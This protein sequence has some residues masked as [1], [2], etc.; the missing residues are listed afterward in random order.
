MAESLCPK[1]RKSID[2]EATVCPYC[3]SAFSPEDMATRRADHKS[4]MVAGGVGC[5]VLVI[6]AGALA[7]CTLREEPKT[8]DQ[9]KAAALQYRGAINRNLSI[10]HTMILVA[11]DKLEQAEAGKTDVVSAYSAIQEGRDACNVAAT[12]ITLLPKITGMPDAAAAVYRRMDMDCAV[13]ARGHVDALDTMLQ[14]LDGKLSTGGLA[15]GLKQ[16]ERTAFLAQ[17]C[18]GDLDA[19][20]LAAGAKSGDLD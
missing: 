12:E 3:Q 17:K 6:A 7:M 16:S 13:A 19:A 15:E 1:C 9:A 5:L 2:L 8:A 4:N 14:S 20:A 11:A 18:R 10:C